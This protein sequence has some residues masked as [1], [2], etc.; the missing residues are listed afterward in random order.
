MMTFFCMCGAV[1]FGFSASTVEVETKGTPSGL[2][3]VPTVVG[4][5]VVGSVALSALAVFTWMQP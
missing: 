4:L 5:H 1:W 2:W 3:I